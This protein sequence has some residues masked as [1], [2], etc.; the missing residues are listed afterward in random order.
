MEP[1]AT[2]VLIESVVPTGNKAHF[3]KHLDLDMLVFAGGKERTEKEFTHL[4]NSTG[5]EL[6]RIVPT[7]AHISMIEAGVR[8]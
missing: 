3:G 5:F 4:L 2:V 7:V 8:P 1:T 6:R